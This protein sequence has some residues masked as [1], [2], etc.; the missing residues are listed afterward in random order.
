MEIEVYLKAFLD[1]LQDGEYNP[2][3]MTELE[4]DD[5]Q[6]H[7]GLK[8]ASAPH[9]D[10]TFDPWRPR[11]IA[12]RGHDHRDELNTAPSDHLHQGRAHVC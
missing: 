4:L 9:C 5:L 2:S 10:E 1:S 3:R 6:R 11:P 7:T 8:V 12:E